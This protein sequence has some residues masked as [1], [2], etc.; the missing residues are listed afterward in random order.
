ML[1][2]KNIVSD[3]LP[4]LILFFVALVAALFI[5]KDYGMSWDEPEQRIM[6]L[7][8]YKYIF[9]NDRT[10]LIFAGADHGVGFELP[11]ACLEKL[12]R[13]QDSR[14]IFL[15]RHI[16]SHIFFLTGA[17]CAYLLALRLFGKQWLACLAFLMIVCNPRIYAHSFF[18]TKDV[19]FMVVMIFILLA[20]HNAFAN[21]KPLWFLLLGAACGYATS[22][23][24]MGV[25]FTGIIAGFLLIDAA[26]TVV[27][28]E[29]A[30]K[31]MVSL[32]LFLV[33][34]VAMLFVM[35]PILWSATVQ[36][37]TANF[38][39][40]AHFGWTGYVLFN[41][42]MYDGPNIPWYYLPWWIGIS[43][44][45]LWLLAGI[46]GI[47]WIVVLALRSP[48][49]YLTDAGKRF[50]LFC[51]I[52]CLLP[53]ASVILLGSV[54]YDDWRHVY[55]IYPFLVILALFAIN[56]LSQMKWGKVVQWAMITQTTAAVFFIISAHPFQQT[57]FNALVPHKDE[58][59]RHHYDLEYWGSSYLQGMQYILA[60]DTSQHITL[61]HDMEPVSNNLMMLPKA[62]RKRLSIVAADQHPD[63]FITNFR[64]HPDEYPYPKIFY[65]IKMV[66]SSALRVY[67]LK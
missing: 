36:R 31:H 59:I 39:A 29:R 19:P 50:F 46:I 33:A 8:S 58:Y 56:E 34:S 20:A 52:C 21:R 14:D 44:P 28:K 18:N 41:G 17:F 13:L 49:T 10:L 35:W 48:I 25:M 43:T 53:V 62:D 32:A 22:I 64:L 6:G 24:I 16:V 12:L 1:Q 47:G 11:L 42:Q 3:H 27:R 23:R 5:Y 63:Y 60:H 67:K 51:L 4:G 54:V 40:L 37:F 57:F 55:F 26:T 45:L 61:M 7:V 38:K 2:K 65:N 66:N 15:M 9:N 30:G